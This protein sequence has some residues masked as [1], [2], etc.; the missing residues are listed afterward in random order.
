MH[1]IFLDNKNTNQRA[2]D[3]RNERAKY[4]SRIYES[5]IRRE[6]LFA[7]CEKN[8]NL[9]KINNIIDQSTSNSSTFFFALFFKLDNEYAIPLRS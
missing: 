2:I 1:T 8:R 5:R 3:M 9:R 6:S 7:T 4:K